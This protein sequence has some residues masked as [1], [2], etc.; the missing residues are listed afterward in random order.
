[1][2]TTRADG[3]AV[4]AAGRRPGRRPG[5]QDTRSEILTAAA[6]EFAERGFA[7]GTVRGIAARADVDPALI[8][9][10]FGSK[11]KLFLATVEIPMDP[12]SIL[13]EIADGD[14]AT[15]GHRLL[16][17]ILSAWESPL[18]PSLI[19]ALRSAI[20]D[21]SLSRQFGEFLGVELIGRLLVHLHTPDDELVLRGGLLGSTVLGLLTARYVLLLPPVVAQDRATLVRSV[22][23]MLQRYLTGELE[24]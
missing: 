6:A 9:H 2:T 10:Y 17:T 19:A 7:A 22:G 1:M 20:A 3:P 18:Q 12:G 11:R 14:P 24:S 15:L 16:D 21:P 23:P 4:P 5:R 8:H 13:D